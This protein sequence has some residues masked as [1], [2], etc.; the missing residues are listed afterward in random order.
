M[1]INRLTGNDSLVI[2]PRR[3]S[4]RTKTPLVI[5]SKYF[6]RPYKRGK[7]KPIEERPLPLS[8]IKNKPYYEK[9]NSSIL[10]DLSN[11]IF[12]NIPNTK[13]QT[14]TIKSFKIKK[15]KKLLI[16]QNSPCQILPAIVS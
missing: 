11:K 16:N 14:K 15:L 2:P 7:A 4:T 3:V 10:F 13:R 9:R 5:D 1:N 8:G 6:E 12:R